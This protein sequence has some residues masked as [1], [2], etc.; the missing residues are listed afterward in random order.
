MKAFVITLEGHA[1][2][3]AKASRCIESARQVGQHVERFTAVAA[4]RAEAVMHG[5]GLRWTWANNNTSPA[6][7][8]HTKLK[9]RPYESW[10]QRSAAQCPITFCGGIA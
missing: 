4:D 10:L 8:P 2:S 7:C 6:V 5:Y 1:Y 9:Q 3:E